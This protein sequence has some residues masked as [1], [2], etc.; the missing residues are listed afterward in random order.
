M[1]CGSGSEGKDK[2]VKARAGKESSGF[3][4]AEKSY[5]LEPLVE[6]EQTWAVKEVFFVLKV[7]YQGPQI[8]GGAIPS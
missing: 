8:E 5:G 7:Y 4:L 2:G 1:S 3:A 6:S